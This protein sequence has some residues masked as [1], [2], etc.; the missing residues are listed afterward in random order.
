MGAGKDANNLN[1]RHRMNRRGLLKAM[2][3]AI[4]IAVVTA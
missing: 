3:A 4:F 1:G 2:G